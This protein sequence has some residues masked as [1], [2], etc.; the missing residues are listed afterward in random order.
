LYCPLALKELKGIKF[1]YDINNISLTGVS[2]A[3]IETH[4]TLSQGSK[5][6]LINIRPGFQVL[7]KSVKEIKKT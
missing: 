1:T 5:H 2:F 4:Q 3:Y 6:V 7:S